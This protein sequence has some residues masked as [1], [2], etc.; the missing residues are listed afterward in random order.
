M[1]FY[2]MGLSTLIIIM[3]AALYVIYCN[4]NKDR[5]NKSDADNVS[6]DEDKAIDELIVQ[7]MEK[8]ENQENQDNTIKSKEDT[9]STL[10]ELH[11]KGNFCP[12]LSEQ[13]IIN[14]VKK[15]LNME[16]NTHD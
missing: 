6:Y 1:F 2:M 14:F 15:K 16:I 5:V 13:E 8:N 11:K 10:V 9:L 7:L 4:I 3:C 12:N